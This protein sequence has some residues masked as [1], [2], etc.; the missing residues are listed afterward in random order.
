MTACGGDHL[1]FSVAQDGSRLLCR[2]RWEQAFAH[3][4]GDGAHMILFLGVKAA[5]FIVFDVAGTLVL[6]A[7]T[8]VE[9]P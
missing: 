3:A 7:G 2:R 4:G 6:L 8:T 1:A 9:H 5:D